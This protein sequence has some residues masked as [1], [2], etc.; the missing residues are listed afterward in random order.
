VQVTTPEDFT[1]DSADSLRNVR[2]L[3]IVSLLTDVS[4]EAIYPILPL[5][6]TN[7]LGVPVTIIGLIESLAEATSSITR[8][9]SGWLSDRMG[10]R[11]PLVLFGYSLSNLAK[12]ALALVPSWPSVLALRMADRLGKGIR[13]APRDALIADSSAPTKRG[14]AFG[15]HRAL[16]TAGAAIG[17]LAA[18]LVLTLSPDG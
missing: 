4:S 13:T 3:G 5:F 10:R 16:D 1:D 6:L 8:V 14:A 18:W 11:R 7:V 12:P 9:I 15:L 2:A 17:P